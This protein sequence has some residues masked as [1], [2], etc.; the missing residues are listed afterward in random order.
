M[1]RILQEHIAAK[2][3]LHPHTTEKEILRYESLHNHWRSIRSRKTSFI[4]VLKECCNDLGE[5]IDVDR[6]TMERTGSISTPAIDEDLRIRNYIEMGVSFTQETT[7]SG[8]KVE[9]TIKQ[10]KAS[11]YH[12]RLFYIGLNSCEE[13]LLRIQNRIQKGGHGIGEAVVRRQYNERWETIF[14][15]LSYCDEAEFYD[16]ENG[17]A[18]VADYRKG[19]LHKSGDLKP[20]WFKELQDCLSL[21]FGPS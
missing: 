11:G 21:R 12:I 10:A 16:N 9:E 4:G 17:F 2:S 8:G 1:P 18:K 15:I 7:F 19:K 20:L 3:S 5:I 6:I 14:R 13:S